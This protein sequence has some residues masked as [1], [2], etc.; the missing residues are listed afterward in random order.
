MDIN[1]K[2]DTATVHKIVNR[3]QIE[4]MKISIINQA[5]KIIRKQI[6]AL[7]YSKLVKIIVKIVSWE[8]LKIIVQLTQIKI[9]V[10][11]K[12]ENLKIVNVSLKIYSIIKHRPNSQ[13]IY[14][15]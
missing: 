15:Q 14:K 9:S 3:W 1:Q 12:R 11:I 7:I 10:R 5:I 8:S 6:K 13:K 4:R 2:V